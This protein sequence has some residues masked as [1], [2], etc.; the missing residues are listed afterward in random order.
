MNSPLFHLK[1]QAITLRKEGKSYGQILKIL[2]LK[3][4]G[5]LSAWFKDLELSEKS[6]ILLKKNNQL[7]SKRR[8]FES[9]TKRTEKIME[10][11]ENSRSIGNTEIGTLSKRELLLVATAL[12]WGEGTKIENKKGQQQIVFTNSDPFM[13][14][15]FLRFLREIWNVKEE[16]IRA[17]IHIY[18]NI[19]PQEAR[20]YWSNI[21]N[22]PIDRFYIVTQVS[23]ASQNKR[24]HNSL[25][26]GTL[27]IKVSGRNL[28]FKMKGM[29]QGIIDNK[30]QIPSP[31]FLL[32]KER[33]F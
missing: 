27:V 33:C 24:P 6:K 12:Y 5:T 11:N 30:P 18:P 3:S 23:R 19:N 31:L 4:K 2:N 10:E 21:T 20:G 15:V 26:Y 14:Q 17:G 32:E 7:A 29:I 22:L 13:I 9:N 28:F 25:P 16:K 8:L 1:Q